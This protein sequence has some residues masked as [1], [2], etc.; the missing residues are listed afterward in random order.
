[1]RLGIS[2][3]C[4]GRFWVPSA[5]CQVLLGF[6]LVACEGN[7][8]NGPSGP[9]CCCPNFE[10]DLTLVIHWVFFPM[11]PQLGSPV[12]RNTCLPDSQESFETTSMLLLLIAS[13]YFGRERG[14][15][16]GGDNS[17]VSFSWMPSRLFWVAA[18]ETKHRYRFHLPP[19][20]IKRQARIVSPRCSENQPGT[21]PFLKILIEGNSCKFVG[22]PSAS[23]TEHR[24]GN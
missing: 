1:M 6:E 17:S 22:K 15:E 7:R 14:G 5:Q 4:S 18:M 20:A 21:Y 3:G 24:L 2:Q 12:T 10:S 8:P 11:V 16:E 13:S 23:G 9:S 19:L